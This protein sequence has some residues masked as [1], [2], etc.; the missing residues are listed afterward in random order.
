MKK[1]TYLNNIFLK[2]NAIK[3]LQKRTK[4]GKEKTGLR[5]LHV[6]N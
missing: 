5:F 1:F 4:Q 2:E 6:Q 3:K